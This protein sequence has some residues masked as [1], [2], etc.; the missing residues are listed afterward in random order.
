MQINRFEI[1][2]VAMPLLEPWRTAYG[3]D[4]A[5][6]SILVK[7]CCGDYAVWSESAPFPA[8][9]YSPEW[10]G[11]AFL[12]IRDRLAPAL[13]G[14]PLDGPDDVTAR[15][16]IYKGNYFA[17]AALD[18]AWWVLHSTMECMPL[19]RALGATRSRVA[20]GADFGIMADIDTLLKAVDRAVAAGFSR[21][22]LKFRPGWDVDMVAA[23]RQ[24]FPALTMHIDCNSA[25]RLDDLPLFRSLDPFNL[26]MIEQPL[27][28]DDLVDHAA[29]AAAIGTPIC[30]DESITSVDRA[31]KAIALKSCGLINIKPGRVGGLTT[32]RAI[33]DLCRDAGVGC[34]IGGM[35]ESAVGSSLLIALAM[36]EGCTYPPDIF[37]TD[38][39]YAEDLA[40]PPTTLTSFEGRVCMEAPDTAGITPSPVPERLDAWCLQ[41]A[42]V[43]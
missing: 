37:P 33:H 28:H 6:E 42:A 20:V 21:V 9:C 34:W 36:L 31:R 8:P 16:S 1:Y 5:V 17:K 23:V 18:N 4:A 3:E 29:L 25:Y 26:A 32:A 35:L 19:H 11:G 27:A 13:L 30:L 22:K 12:L 7:A 24:A 2:H 14:V 15:L 38:R 10:A 39:F 40:D 43:G 41:R